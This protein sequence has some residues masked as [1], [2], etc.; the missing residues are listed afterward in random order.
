MAYCI[1]TF[2]AFLPVNKL[3][4]QYDQFKRASKIKPYLSLLEQ[5][6]GRFIDVVVFQELIPN[7]INAVVEKDLKSIG[8][9]HF[10]TNIFKGMLLNGGIRVFSRHVITQSDFMTFGDV[11]SG[12]DCFASKGVLYTRIL[13]GDQILNLFSLHLQATEINETI[14][15]KQLRLMNDYIR[16]FDIDDK[17]ELTMIAGDF[18]IDRYGHEY[19]VFQDMM[20]DTFTLLDIDKKFCKYTRSVKNSLVGLDNPFEY[21][22]STY[23]RGCV[24]KYLKDFK[25]SCCVNEW[26]DYILIR[27]TSQHLLA[28]S[29]SY[30]NLKMKSLNVQVPTFRMQMMKNTYHNVNYISDHFPVALEFSFASQPGLK[31]GPRLI[32]E[33]DKSYK[34]LAKESTNDLMKRHAVLTQAFI[35]IVLVFVSLIFLFF[36][37][38]IWYK[39]R[40]R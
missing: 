16:K 27:K 13:L 30:L 22:N 1:V 10:S 36:V 17:C 32:I 39:A 34:T 2:N 19:K 7:S 3:I 24:Q 6:L 37:W 4:K 29:H 28:S 26:L 9:V 18:N 12:S 21:K 15:T 33:K 11:C 38:L 31:T 40:T 35:V 8:F 5:H 25:C 14:R 20:R 23:P